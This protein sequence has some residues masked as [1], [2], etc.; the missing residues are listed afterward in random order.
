MTKVKIEPGI[1]GLITIVEAKSEDQEFAKIKIESHCE[2][3]KKLA[4]AI[5]EEVNS[6][7][8]AL[9]KPGTGTIYDAAK[10]C[11][12]IHASCPVAAGII[13]CIE[14]ECKLALPKDVSIKFI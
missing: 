10:E 5:G 3:I 9:S 11:C 12:P 2:E 8:A 6:F 14:V 7:D 13:K 1:C 4:K